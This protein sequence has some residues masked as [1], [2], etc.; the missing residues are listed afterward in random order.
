MKDEKKKISAPIDDFLKSYA[1]KSPVRCHMPGGKGKND[2]FDITEIDGADSLFESCGIIAES[3]ENA[4]RLFGAGKTLFSCGGSTLSVQTMLALAKAE[5][6][7]KHRVIAGRYCHKSLISACVLLDLEVDWIMP[8]EYLSC[9]ISKEEVEAK[10]NEDTLC[11]FAQSIDYYGGECDIRAVSEAC[12]AKNIPLLVDNAHGA[13]L[14][15]TDRHPLKSGAD[16]TADSAHKTLPCLTGC[17]YLH[18]GKD[19]RF[20]AFSERAKELMALFGSSSPSYLMLQSLDL[21]NRFIGEESRCAFDALEKIKELKTALSQLGFGLYESDPIR[22]TVDCFSAGYGGFELNKLLEEQNIF[23]EYFDGRYV[24]LLFSVSQD[25]GDLHKILRAFEKIPIKEKICA[26]KIAPRLPKAVV[27]PKKAVFSPSALVD[28]ENA[29]GRICGEIRCS[30]PPCVPLIMPGELF[31][32]GI[33]NAVREYGA[34]KVRILLQ[35]P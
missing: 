6:P 3:E 32:D 9:K 11:V 21:C 17:G 26:A 22:I 16:M 15:F 20:T 30:C 34:D 13:Y 29:K 1:A 8:A 2:P 24:V 31:D 4:A 14:V 12:R 5:S 7:E 19:S 10:I 25:L 23:C 28:T 18:I 35:S 27:S 33:I